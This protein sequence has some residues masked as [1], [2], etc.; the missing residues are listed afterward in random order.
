METPRTRKVLMRSAM[1]M[2][3][4]RDGIFDTLLGL[5][6]VG[7]GGTSGNG[8]QYMSWIH[9][10]DM[11]RAVDWLIAHESLSGPVNLASPQP[12]PNAAFMAGLR[13]AW[14]M[15]IGLPATEW[16]LAIGAVAMRTETELVLKSRRVTPGKMLASGFEF[17]FP[18]WPDAAQDLC[19]RWR[20]AGKN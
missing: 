13:T 4:D 10:R 5:V 15:P 9:D 8:K 2:S 3:P 19:T 12:L 11:I 17:E 7:L 1:V 20:A 6:R 14:G 18:V 16:M